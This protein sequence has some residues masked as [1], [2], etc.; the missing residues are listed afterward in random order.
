MQ[1]LRI[2]RLRCRRE[3]AA[4]SSPGTQSSNRPGDSFSNGGWIFRFVPASIV[5]YSNVSGSFFSTT[6]YSLVKKINTKQKLSYFN[7]LLDKKIHMAYY[8]R[9]LEVLLIQNLI[10]FL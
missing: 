9:V 8:A 10:S 6:A 2:I 4:C 3:Q 7:V 5:T 1:A